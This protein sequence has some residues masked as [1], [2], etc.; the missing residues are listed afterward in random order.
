MKINHNMSALIANKR[1]LA[2]D[3]SLSVS[4]ERLSTGFRINRAS[5]DAAGMAISTKMKAQI[6]GLAQA[7]RNASD[8]VSV[9]DTA[10]G[11]LTEVH[12]M[13]QRMRE[14]SVQA[15]N[16]TNTP[17]DLEAIQAEISSLRDEIDRISKDTE[18]NT[19][20]LLD[21]TL[22]QRVFTD[23]RGITRMDISDTVTANDYSITVVSDATHALVAG[24]A[25]I[26]PAATAPAEGVVTINGVGVKI[27]QGDTFEEVYEKL[28]EG[29]GRGEVNLLVSAT[30][31]P[32]TAT[33]PATMAGKPEDAGYVPTDVTNGGFLIFVSDE[34]GSA[35]ELDLKCDSQELADFL[36]IPQNNPNVPHGEDVKVEF[37]TTGTPAERVGFGS[38]ATILAEGNYVTISDRNGF[39]M[40]FEVTPGQ[41]TPNSQV[42]MEVTNIGTMTLQIGANENQTVDVRIPEVS[43]RTLYID[44][45]NVCTVTGAD[46]AITSFD[47]AIAKVSEVRSSIGAYQNRLDYAVSSLDGTELNMTQ[48]LSRIED[49]DMAEEMTEYTKYNVLTQAATS[50]LAQANDIPQQVLQLLQ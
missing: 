31:T 1:L 35:T 16:E 14:L 4:I 26:A 37:T 23:N 44:K 33:P 20:H 2:S 11:A 48:A 9:L 47:G 49:V 22:D 34:Y 21:G 7:S 12:A 6:K 45:V 30:Q 39:E 17:D 28:R 40:K 27:S 10:D 13:L 3:K 24:T 38:Q 19:K 25:N 15:A 43:S 18:F 36:G 41:I 5:D 50:V 32:P 29:A 8:G 42:N 46:R